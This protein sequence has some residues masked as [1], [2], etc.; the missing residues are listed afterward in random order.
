MMI[1]PQ[2]MAGPFHMIDDVSRGF[3]LDRV[4]QEHTI[5]DMFAD[6]RYGILGLVM[7]MFISTAV[8]L[9]CWISKAEAHGVNVLFVSLISIAALG[10]TVWQIR[11]FRFPAVTC[12]VLA[13]LLL[14]VFRDQLMRTQGLIISSFV[15][16]IAVGLAIFIP[17]H[18]SG[19]N[20]HQLMSGDECRDGDF[21]ALRGMNDAVLAAP[22]GLSLTL[23][24]EQADPRIASV[25]FH[26]DSPNIKRM[27]QIFDDAYAGDRNAAAAPL[28][29]IA[30]CRHTARM[31]NSGASLY[32]SLARGDDWP[33]LE[34]TNEGKGGR[35]VLYKIDHEA[36]R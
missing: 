8:G 13:P 17:V 27:A 1:A 16:S 11:F 14:I 10:L 4:A 33:G 26:R 7:L 28:T 25:Y 5:F 18:Q 6:A 32:R 3:W 30:V 36:F 21:S 29:H 31:A 19:L 23:L 22:L 12:A 24:K 15:T 20:E 2:C 9:Y 34:L 35:F